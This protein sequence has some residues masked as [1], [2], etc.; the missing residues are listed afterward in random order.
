MA[1]LESFERSLANFFEQEVNV[2]VDV[3]FEGKL[4]KVKGGATIPSGFRK[5]ITMGKISKTFEFPN[6]NT[7][8]TNWIDYLKN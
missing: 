4:K 2:R 1:R 6:K 3:L 5:T 7:S 8:G